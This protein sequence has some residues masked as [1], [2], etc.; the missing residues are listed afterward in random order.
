LRQIF[1]ATK[2]STMEQPPSPPPLSSSPF[3]FLNRKNSFHSRA[4]SRDENMLR[5]LTLNSSKRAYSQAA[6]EPPPT[7]TNQ[8]VNPD[9][10]RFPLGCC[11]LYEIASTSELL[12]RCMSFAALISSSKLLF[13]RTSIR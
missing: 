6:S 1:W 12:T 7:T 3:S 8:T 5:A 13:L 11:M 9:I 10:D 4:L 2:Q